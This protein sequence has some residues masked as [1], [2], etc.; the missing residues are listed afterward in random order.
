MKR[1]ISTVSAGLLLLIG[2]SFTAFAVPA[3]P[4]P[5]QVMQPDGTTITIQM[6]GDEFLNWT[7]SGGR[8]VTKGADGFYYYGDFNADGSVVPTTSRVSTSASSFAFSSD[9]N[10]T[11]PAA[12]IMAAQAKKQAFNKSLASGINTQGDFKALVLLIEFKDLQFTVDNPVQTFTN[13]LNEKGYN[14]NGATGSAYD[15]YNENS[16]G[17]FNPQFDVYGPIQCSKGYAYYGGGSD[18]KA[19]YLLAE[20]C[21]LI[22]SQLD[23]SQYDTDKDGYV[24]NVFF[25]YAGH[26]EAE[27]AGSE[28]IWPHKWELY[29]PGSVSCDGVKVSKYACTSE[30]SG[31]YGKSLAHIGTFCHEFGHVIGLPDFYDTDYEQNGMAAGIGNLSLMSG[32]SYNNNSA[33]PPYLNGVERILLGWMDELIPLETS[34]THTLEPIQNNKAYY[35]P[36]ANPGEYYMYECRNEQGWDKGIEAGGLAIY[37]VDQSNNN[38]F[39]MT[40]KNRWDYWNGINDYKDHQCFDLIESVIENDNGYYY[41]TD[42]VFPGRTNKTSF[43]GTTNQ[44][45]LDWK[46]DPTGYDLTDITYNGEVSFTLKAGGVKSIY[47]TVK[48]KKGNLLPDAI[49]TVYPVDESEVSI[50]T[51]STFASAQGSYVVKSDDKGVYEIDLAGCNEENFLIRCSYAGFADFTQVVNISGGKKELNIKLSELSTDNAFY[52]LGFNVIVSPKETYK[53]GDTFELQLTQSNKVVKSV[54]WFMDSNAISGS[55][56]NLQAGE[57][58]IKAEITYP[59]GEVEIEVLEI[60]VE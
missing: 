25:F 23:F 10:V 55:S 3:K 16:N 50:L 22:D 53:A 27:G 2:I 26:N 47:G 51:A 5:V 18:E 29:R 24:D 6:H 19:D 45:A 56:V 34:G 28:Y 31:S 60:K 33:T 49:V 58:T 48:N 40:A 59:G 20:A 54:K 11:P 13:L 36:T 9:N 17:V 14:K 12:A 8:L 43:T 38:V 41:N 30:Y 35:T 46:G 1:I 21:K 32:G 39:G 37:H 42:L 7:T 44:G 57:H 15:Y 52:E 4:T